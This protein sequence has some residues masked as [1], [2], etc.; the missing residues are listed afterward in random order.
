[1]TDETTGGAVITD[2]AAILGGELVYEIAG[3]DGTN[4]PVV[5]LHGGLLD[6]RQWD[7]EFTAVASTHRVIRFDARGHGESSLA[8][9]DFAFHADLVALLDHLEVRR[10]TAVGLSLGA[11]TI[12]TPRWCIRTG[13]ARSCSCRPVTAGSSSPIRSCWS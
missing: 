4:D 7:T 10:V 6:R 13:S 1:M 2:R 5:T 9:C 12:T 3:D 11:R 8:D